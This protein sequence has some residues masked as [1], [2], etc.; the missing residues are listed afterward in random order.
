MIS[1]RIALIDTALST[2]ATLSD[3]YIDKVS[4]FPAVAIL[5]RTVRRSNIGASVTLD[6]F[7]FIVRGYVY[8]EEDDSLAASEALA[9]DIEFVIQSIRSPI[10]YDA[11]VL[12]VETDEGLLS[13]YG[14][15]DVLCI[16]RW[17]N[18]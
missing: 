7:E 4:D 13:P 12:S 14:M 5:R 11:H 9:R 6:S 1:T 10:I 17:I 16:V 2:I 3:G 18:E 15:C 8:T